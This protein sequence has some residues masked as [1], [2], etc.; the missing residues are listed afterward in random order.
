MKR[1]LTVVLGQQPYLVDLAI[2]AGG[3]TMWGRLCLGLPSVVARM[4]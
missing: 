1:P 3:T 2:G 4:A